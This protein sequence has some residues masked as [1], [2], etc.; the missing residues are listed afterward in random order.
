ML[1]EMFGLK[2]KKKAIFSSPLNIFFEMAISDIQTENVKRFP[3]DERLQVDK[4][5]SETKHSY[6]VNF[7]ENFNII[8]PEDKP[9]DFLMKNQSSI[10]IGS[11][12]D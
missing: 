7:R 5:F 9:N 8:M 2:S 6:N 12:N 3:R 10:S 1:A 4:I 11:D